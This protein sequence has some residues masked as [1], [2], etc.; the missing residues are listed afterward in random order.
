[1]EGRICFFNSARI[2]GGGEKWHLEA[3][4]VLHRNGH[5][6]LLVANGQGQLYK[7]AVA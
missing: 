1:M 6:V 3:A 2:W 5:H 4:G 7:R